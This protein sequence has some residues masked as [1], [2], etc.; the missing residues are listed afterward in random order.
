MLVHVQLEQI[1]GS[2]SR[3]AHDRDQ[4]EVTSLGDRV[5]LTPSMTFVLCVT[6]SHCTRTGIPPTIEN[7]ERRKITHGD[8]PYNRRCCSTA[9]ANARYGRQDW[10]EPPV[11]QLVTVGLKRSCVELISSHI[12]RGLIPLGVVRMIFYAT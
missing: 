1:R 10:S 8:V 4:Y 12:R 9:F 2:R 6:A 11:F 3:I 7:G 5:V